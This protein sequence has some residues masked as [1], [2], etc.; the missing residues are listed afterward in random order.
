MSCLYFAMKLIEEY[1]LLDKQYKKTYGN[2]TFLLYQVGSFFEVYGI[3]N[4]NDTSIKKFS[5]ICNLAIANKKICIGKNNV[6]MSGFRDFL[7][8]K[9]IEKVY[10]YG[11]SVVVYIQEEKEDGT[12]VR[13]KQGVYSPGTTF[14]EN[15][16]KLSN[17]ISCIW[18]QR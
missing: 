12:I 17:N 5:E 13:N 18:I 1:F 10:P 16:N 6:L 4:E 7:L 11:Y 14:L 2:K 8:E 9:Y 3:E 15:S